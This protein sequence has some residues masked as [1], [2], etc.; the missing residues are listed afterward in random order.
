M[1]PKV[2]SCQ[3]Y[4]LNTNPDVQKAGFKCNVQTIAVLKAKKNFLQA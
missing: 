2:H 4:F 1:K 3:I